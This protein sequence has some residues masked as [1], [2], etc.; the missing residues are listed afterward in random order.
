MYIKVFTYTQTGKNVRRDLEKEITKNGTLI[1]KR[2]NEQ[3]RRI[4]NGQ[5]NRKGLLRCLHL[6]D[7]II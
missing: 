5:S 1:V 2:N 7:A 3:R 6:H 4:K